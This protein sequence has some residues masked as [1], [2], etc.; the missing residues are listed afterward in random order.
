MEKN[1]HLEQ[2]LQA[3]RVLH[4]PS[5]F[6]WKQHWVNE[7]F[8]HDELLECNEE[9]RR[10]FD[11]RLREGHVT[12]SENVR[13]NNCYSASLKDLL[14]KLMDPARKNITKDK[15]TIVYSSDNG[16]RPVG[17]KAFETWGG[18]QVID[19]D[20]KNR[21]FAVY[22]K[23]KLFCRLKKYNWFLG[24]A[25][26][27]SGK[28]LHIYTKIQVSESEEKDIQK[29]KLLYLTNF[30]HKYSYVYLSCLQIIKDMKNEDGTDVTKEQLLQWLDFAMFKPQQGAFIGYDD[31]PLINTHY[32]EDFIY[33]NFDNVE[34]MGCP[35]VDWV[36][37]PD[38]KEAFKRWEWFEE[39]DKPLDVEITDVQ[40]LEVDTHN[41]VH[42]KHGDRW[43]LANTLVK[44]YGVDQGFKYLRMICSSD[45]P[46]KEIQADCTTAARHDKPVDLWAVNRLNKVH[47]FK[48]KVSIDKEEADLSQIYETLEEI[49]NPTLIKESDNNKTYYIKA[50]EYLG[51]IRHELLKDI[52]RITLIEAGAG[53]GKTEMVKQLVNEGYKIMMVM[54]FTSTIKS[55]VEGD[56]NWYYSYGNRK[57][58][59]YNNRGCSL[60]VDKFSKLNLMEIKEAGFDYIFLDESHLLFQSEYRPVMP[61]VIEMIRN[62]EIPIILMSGTPVGETVFFEDIVHL[63]VIKEDT[64]KKNFNVV[65]CDKP[66]DSLLY[67]CKAM[68]KDVSE[69]RRVLFPTNR[70][71]DFKEKVH[72]MI[73]YFLEN[74]FYCFR[75]PIVN[76]Y[77]K[78]NLGEEFMDSV[79][80]KKT[81][82]NTDVLMCTNYLSVGVD[83]LD[84]YEFNIY[85][86]DILMPQEVEQFANRL[87]SHDLFI[88]LYVSRKNEQG[89]SLGISKYHH[90][91]FKLDDNEIKDVHSILRLC[92]AMIERNP[93]EYKY[94][95]L[96]ANIIYN[97][98]YIEYN[99]IENKYYLNEIAY[100]TIMFERK[101]RE[102]VQQ[103]P[104]LVKGMEAYGYNYSSIDL[105]EFKEFV[106]E[107]NIK[108]ATV[109]KSMVD[110]AHRNNVLHNTEC[111]E[112]L[113]ELIT[114]D[115]LGVYKDVMQG[116]YEIK[117]GKQWSDSPIDYTMTV[118]NVE[119]FEKVVPLFVS[120]SKMF[121]IDDIKDIFNH[122]RNKDESFNYAAI[123]RIKLLTNIIYNSKRQRLDLPLNQFM[124]ETYHFVDNNPKVKKLEIIR[125]I[126]DFV[127]RYATNDSDD[128]VKIFNSP[129]TLEHMQNILTDIFKCL[130]NVGKSRKDVVD[131]S[132]VELLW[133][134]KEDKV[135]ETN[136]MIFLLDDFIDNVKIKEI[137]HNNNEGDT[138]K[139]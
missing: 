45:I 116:R 49:D 123:K 74:D 52:G 109:L 139:N 47:G 54:P 93:V 14:N 96:I 106:G 76:Y 21:E 117:K 84:R 94:N 19:M 60:T 31:H 15:R 131:L 89:D 25:F 5:Q 80:F 50:N 39:E 132:R 134:P 28:G 48:I 118:R 67:M 64:R 4:T 1:L 120:M 83:I 81:I 92:N 70:G 44:L 23:K 35:D 98:K 119:V 138:E 91:N 113:M 22:L 24:V 27:S 77:K 2:A 78:S 17:R 10:Q 29:K 12:M 6:S 135:S 95:T 75:E 133:T 88:N 69:G 115:R 59:L 32:F 137:Y 129:L 53:V 37:Y 127:M 36:S 124:N 110:A 43:R 72:S 41:R 111:V 9:E 114:E 3:Y 82:D 68:A 58:D 66:S 62:T 38:L 122:C 63:H 61:K 121:D 100:K 99:D 42:Y 102:Y 20:I 87:R 126:N 86:N 34:D 56:K 16:E 103:L 85:F 125:F 112:E 11:K 104:V 79:N 101:Y 105:G 73:K 51:N 90:M 7:V 33:V 46:T 128:R 65:I 97:N 8:T 26:S 18:F 108:K 55:K 13:S 71:V 130:V 136:R 107:D 40:P 57:I 30:R